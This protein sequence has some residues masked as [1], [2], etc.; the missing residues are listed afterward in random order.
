MRQVFAEIW[1]TSVTRFT[2][3]TM[4]SLW[5]AHYST[6]LVTFGSSCV[7]PSLKLKYF[8]VLNLN[9]SF[10]II[11]LSGILSRGKKVHFDNKV[12]ISF[13]L[14]KLLNV[15]EYVTKIEKQ[16]CTRN[17]QFYAHILL[18]EA[19]T[20]AHQFPNFALSGRNMSHIFKKMFLT[21]FI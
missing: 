14:C 18:L 9:H 17:M 1:G 21:A 11:F 5:K 19:S 15:T 7:C 16:F 8:F 6:V 3:M 20:T 12:C 4:V 10:T 2:L 13:N